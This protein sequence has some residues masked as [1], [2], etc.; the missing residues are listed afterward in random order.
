MN[1]WYN[2][3]DYFNSVVDD[4]YLN[5][6]RTTTNLINMLNEDDNEDILD[7]DNASEDDCYRER[8]GINGD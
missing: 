4:E 1:N 6:F 8:I 2:L 7:L 5:H 3:I